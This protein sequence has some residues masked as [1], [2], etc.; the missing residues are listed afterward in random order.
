MFGH[1]PGRGHGHGHGASGGNPQVTL[2]WIPARGGQ[3]PNGAIQVGHGV[4][5]AR[6]QHAG[7]L[8]PGKASMGHQA[9]YVSY[10]GQEHAVSDYEILCDTHMQCF[11]C[12]YTW[13][14]CHGRS[15]P[16]G[17]LIGGYS[18]DRQPYYIGRSQIN[19]EMV[20]GKVFE[21]HGCAY[22]PWGGQEHRSNEFEILVLKQ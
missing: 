15:V 3:I 5:V 18:A 2:S 16:R 11:G 7:E 4:F 6:A 1:G 10:G 8:I 17:A 13:E 9:A 12:N 21:P 14:R 22:F 20:A 19:G